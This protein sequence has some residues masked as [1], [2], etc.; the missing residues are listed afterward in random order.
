MTDCFQP[1][2]KKIEYLK[3]ITNFKYKSV[4]DDEGRAY[5]YWKN[6]YNSNPN[7]CCNLRI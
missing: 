6:N 2:E 5:E 7:N 3:N 4:C 1:I